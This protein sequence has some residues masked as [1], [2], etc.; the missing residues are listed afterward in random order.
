MTRMRTESFLIL[1]AYHLETPIAD[2]MTDI[3]MF[4][5]RG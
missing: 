2:R 5:S 3:E 4:A 1:L